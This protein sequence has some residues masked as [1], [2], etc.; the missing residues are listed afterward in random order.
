VVLAPQTAKVF[1]TAER[2]GA[3]EDREAWIPRHYGYD[4]LAIIYEK[5]GKFKEAIKLCETGRSQ[6]WANEFDKRLV[7]L[8]K[9]LKNNKA[10]LPNPCPNTCIKRL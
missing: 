5:Q 10:N 3:T 1:A 9:K 4:Q 8:R 6:G 7:R 2:W